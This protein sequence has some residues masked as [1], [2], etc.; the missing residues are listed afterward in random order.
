MTIRAD[1]DD[2]HFIVDSVTG[3]PLDLAVAGPGGRSFAFIIDFLIRLLA[4]VAWLFGFSL[5]MPA[6]A[7]AGI[8]PPTWLALLSWVP[9]AA[10][11]LLYHPIFEILMG[12]RTPGK[13]LA[14]V[15]IVTVD[16]MV[17]GVGPIAV[18]SVFRLVDSL[19]FFYLVG[20]IVTIVTRRSQRIGDLAAGT[21]LIYDDAGKAETLV[22][23]QSAGVSSGLSARDAEVVQELIDR[24]PTLADDSRL[25]MAGALLARIEPPES[26]ATRVA[27]LNDGNALAALQRSLGGMR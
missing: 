23:I 19:P 21:L 7:A 26:A 25:E 11:F 2:G 24:W 12:G 17:P 10:F 14:G 4:S 8:N 18:R 27:L 22:G 1:T 3:V 13:H 20:L 6:L 16:G 5:L 9:A 15:R